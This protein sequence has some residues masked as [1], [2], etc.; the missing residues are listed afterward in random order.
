MAKYVPLINA[1]LQAKQLVESSKKLR[2]LRDGGETP[3]N[4]SAFETQVKL[5]LTGNVMG[6]LTSLVDDFELVLSTEPSDEPV[7]GGFALLCTL[8]FMANKPATHALAVRLSEVVSA[9]ADHRAM[10][11]L[12]LL[13]NL[14][15]SFPPDATSRFS[16]LATLLRFARDADL[17]SAVSSQLPHLPA[18][19]VRFGATPDLQLQLHQLAYQL[20]IST[21][22]PQAFKQLIHVMEC[23]ENQSD[24]VIT[25]VKEDAVKLIVLAIALPGQFLMDHLL[26]YK[27]VAQLKDDAEHKLVYSLLSLFVNDSYESFL[28][29]AAA[30]PSVFADHNL[31]VE[32]CDRKMRLLALAS[33]ASAKTVLSF[34]EVAAA[35]KV[36]EDEVE[37]WVIDALQYEVLTGSIDQLEQRVFIT[38][39][40]QRTF[41]REQWEEINT[42]LGAWRANI[43]TMLESL[44]GMQK[45]QT[46]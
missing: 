2:E 7:E 19:C 39:A 31:I 33:A 3:E 40:L 30:N 36:P 1:P 17:A 37:D 34:A 29:F 18:W 42:K 16:V 13:H 23:A 9:R 46:V 12:T 21:D 20:I 27:A 14:L 28:S 41:E 38:R 11:R 8:L 35:L 44:D 15:N 45:F 43:A 6:L 25:S 22:R 26:E 24:E 5:A 10:L 4:K 32:Q